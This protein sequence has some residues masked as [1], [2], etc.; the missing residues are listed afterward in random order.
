LAV[1]HP[2]PDDYDATVERNVREQD[3]DA[4]LAM[5]EPLPSLDGD[6]VVL[7]ASPIRNVRP[8]MIIKTFAEALDFTGKTVH[9]VT[10]HAM[11]GLP[12]AEFDHTA[13]CPGATLAEVRPFRAKRLPT[14]ATPPAGGSGA[15]VSPR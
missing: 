7:L 15:Q 13:A 14:S 4:R 3:A 10:T 6:D 1:G 8:P 11:S 2:Y 12:T 5:A 9:P